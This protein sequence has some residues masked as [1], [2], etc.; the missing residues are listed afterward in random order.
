[1]SDLEL[2]A[3]LQG[4]VA[5]LDEAPDPVFAE[6]MMGDGLAV[7]PTGSTLHAPC[8][9]E[10]V[11]VHRTRHAVTLRAPNGAEILMHVGL[12]TV[13]LDG[14]GFQVHVRD[15]QAVRAGDLLVSFDL[16]LLA[17]KARSLLTPVVVA[18][19]DAFAV[20]RREQDRESA[21]G[22]PFMSLRRREAGSA[23]AA[24][25]AAGEASRATVV[26]LAHG[27]HAR[28]AA[29]LA[30]RARDFSATAWLTAGERRADARSLVA[31]MALGLRKGDPVTV[32]ARGAD[33]AALVDA[34]IALIEG[35]F[36]EAAEAAPVAASPVADAGDPNR[37]RGVAGAPGL[38]V[39]QAVRLSLADIAVPERG[40]DPAAES[41]ALTRARA[42]AKAKLEAAAERGDRA[43]REILTAHA[44]LLDDPELVA[45]ARARVDGGA[46]AGLAWR[47]AVRAYVVVLQGLGDPRMAERVADLLDVERQVLA[48]LYPEQSGPAQVLPEDAILLADELL[49]SQ[50]AALDASRVAGFC[51]ARGGPTSHV[52][53]LA[54]SMGVPA[55]VAAGPRVLEIPEGRTLILDADAGVLH[56]APRPQEAAA[57]RA[58]VEARRRR[59]AE[60]RTLAQEPAR[61]AEG[62]RIEVFA[63]LG[64]AAEAAP[65]VAA[66]A[67]GCGLLRTEFLFQ[68]RTTPPDEDEQAALYQAVAD[69][70][71]GRP[72]VI[73]T[74]DAGGDKPIPY[75][76][77]P[78][79]ENP[80]LGLRGV[81]AS[82]WRPELLHTQLRA[83][84]RVRSR[85]P[86]SI[87]LPMIASVGELRTVRRALDEARVERRHADPVPLG[88]MI[89]TPASAALADRLAEEADFFSIGTNDLTQYVLAMDR[90]NPQLAAEM[91]ALH[92]AVLR[93]IDM[94]V[95]GARARSRPV[96]VCGGTASDPLAAPVLIGLGVYR[97][98]ATPAAISGLKALI[99]TLPA[100]AC[101][102]LA[103][104]ALALDSAAD[105]RALVRARGLSF[106][107][108]EKG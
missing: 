18:N 36:E 93:M 9:G 47:A 75:L 101:R 40:A 42:E 49:P 41:A 28:P 66:G 15:G 5:P 106:D 26:A 20:V 48:A 30:K 71:Q 70:L 83:A 73:R 84:L 59:E 82:L 43:R 56:L 1:M 91:D 46:S 17:R 44:A 3:P 67:E 74:L 4:W 62:L 89:E 10:I 108:P 23:G 12:E 94:T 85:A 58:R 16:D 14:E 50:L 38:A 76:P 97:L 64:S 57:A 104:E 27:L 53:I 11:S 80:A 61:T 55:L 65:A 79:E 6:R 96:A 63:N 92:P 86:V 45:A 33:A 25:A 8:D 52:A 81:R 99:R 102:E 69:G 34:I 77:T 78:P 95:R 24:E 21:V 54:A 88:V 103:R 31:L 13:T 32:G 98:S 37:L 60:A 100:G 39:G 22:A 35:G 105:V 7:D 51:T 87:M 2:L 68:D 107:A 90:T 19:S 72:L 29:A